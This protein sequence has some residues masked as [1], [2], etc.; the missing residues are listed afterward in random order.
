MKKIEELVYVTYFKMGEIDIDKNEIANIID[1]V[2]KEISLNVFLQPS[3]KRKKFIKKTMKNYIKTKDVIQCV[4]VAKKEMEDKI[5]AQYN[6][7]DRKRVGEYFPEL[8]KI[9]K[10]NL[11]M[12][13]SEANRL[14]GNKIIV[15]ESQ[16]EILLDLVETHTDEPILK[17]VLKMSKETYTEYIGEKISCY[18]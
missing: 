18:I 15:I 7:R 11:V 3:K 10:E 5:T 9:Q 6:K 4:C 16:L 1:S 13:I 2:R 12:K 14:V 8:T 17:N